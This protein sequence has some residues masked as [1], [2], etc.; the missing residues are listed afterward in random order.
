MKFTA[1]L[2]ILFVSLQSLSSAAYDATEKLPNDPQHGLKQLE[3]LGVDEQLGKQIDLSLQFTNEQGQLV[4]LSTY[5]DGKRPVLLTMVYYGCPSLC[6]YHLNGLID[7][8][9]D[10]DKTPVGSDFQVV[11]VSMNHREE[12][13]LAA[14]KLETYLNAL[15]QDSAK[16]GMHF[17]VGTEENVAKLASEI[18]FKFRWDEKEQQYAHAAVAY[19]TTPTGMISRYL[20]GIEFDAKTLRL[21]LVEA[22][23]GKIGNLIEQVILFCFQFN[24]SKNKYTLYSFNIMRAAG[25]LTVLVLAVLLIPVWRRERKKKSS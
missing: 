16:E 20:Y 21:S 8:F 19:V 18:G 14:A 22:A 15:G 13:D 25:A 5:Y 17:L 2:L 12:S 1:A 3:G 7:T 9:K 4:P 6:N 24:P 10:M 11:A 23:Q